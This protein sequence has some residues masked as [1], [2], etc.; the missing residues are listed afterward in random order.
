MPQKVAASSSFASRQPHPSS[1]VQTDDAHLP[2]QQNLLEN[3]E[4]GFQNFVL[5]F[6]F[7]IYICWS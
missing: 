4:R 6:F 5:K 1:K 3:V 7:G 2:Q